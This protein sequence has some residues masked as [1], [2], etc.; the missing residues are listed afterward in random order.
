MYRKRQIGWIILLPIPLVAAAMGGAALQAPDPVLRVVLLVFCVFLTV[1][2]LAFSSL[3]VT[4]DATAVKAA[5]TLPLFARSIPLSDIAA[6]RPVRNK[7]WYGWGIRFLGPDGWM[8][9]VQGLDAVELELKEGKKFRIGTDDPA[10]L[11][12]A[13]TAKIGS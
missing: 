13:I 12:A 6:A 10:G 7:W 11:T 1:V 3:N 5:F 9:N 8:F 2:L 4:V